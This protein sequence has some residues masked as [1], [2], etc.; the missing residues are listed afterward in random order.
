MRILAEAVVAAMP[1]RRKA[2]VGTASYQLYAL[3]HEK[4]R[5]RFVQ[6]NAELYRQAAEGLLLY[7]PEHELPLPAHRKSSTRSRRRTVVP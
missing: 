4:M 2:A 6:L 3:T 5:V 7:V 1:S